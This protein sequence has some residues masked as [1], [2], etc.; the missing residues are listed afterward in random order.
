MK[1]K[2]TFL[3]VALLI[4]VLVLGVGYAATTKKLQVN[5]IATGVQSDENFNVRFSAVAP[6]D[7]E[8]YDAEG[9]TVEIDAADT[10]QRT[11]TMTVQLSKVGSQAAATFTF[12]N[13]SADGIG[14][15]FDASNVTITTADGQEFSSE[16]FTIDTDLGGMNTTLD[17]QQEISF[18]VYVTLDK[19]V[20][21]DENHEEQFFI[22]LEGFTPVAV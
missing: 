10:T 6:G 5:G 9:V 16:Y 1:K 22:N 14:A 12:I 17:P 20:I 2:N 21:G 7:G 3:V 4:A 15:N 18:T 13:D 11:A 8:G 19:A